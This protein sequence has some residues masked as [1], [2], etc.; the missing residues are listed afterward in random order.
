MPPAFSI[1]IP[2]LDEEKLLPGLLA[3]F[4]VAL[5]GEFGIE[6]IVS[7]GG[8]RDRTRDIAR[9]NGCAVVEHAGSARQTIAGGRNAGA[10]G[11]AGTVLVFLNA[12]IRLADA[13]AFFNAAAGVMARS[14]V[15]GA[16]ALVRVFPEEERAS[17]RVF[18]TL[19]SGY[20]RL[21]NAIGEGMGRGECQLV[22]A[23]L[24]RRLGGYNPAMVAGED[25][26]LFRRVRRTGKVALL[27]GIVV[28]ESPRR[29]RAYGYIRILLGWFRNA[30]SVVLWK[31]SSSHVWETIR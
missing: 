15:A 6:I 7:D 1:V 8:S 20:I 10:E 11:A 17:D 4:P 18:H 25:Y 2:A 27:P 28:Y 3:Q 22:R 29:Y 24:F 12:D 30:V 26:D 19:H 5:R 31:K 23:E 16:T 9:E 21:L 13:R 14:D